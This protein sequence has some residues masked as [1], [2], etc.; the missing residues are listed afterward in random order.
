MA[1]GSVG[2][3][4]TRQP[5]TSEAWNLAQKGTSARLGP[6][7]TSSLNDLMRSKLEKLSLD[8]L[9]NVA[10]AAGLKL[11]IELKDVKAA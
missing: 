7:L 4:A 1:G 9:L 10:A 11:Q 2:G 3:S 8:A 6:E 5:P